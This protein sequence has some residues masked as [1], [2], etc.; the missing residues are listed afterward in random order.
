MTR[1]LRFFTI[2][3]LNCYNSHVKITAKTPRLEVAPSVPTRNEGYTRRFVDDSRLLI[4]SVCDQCG[5]RI[6][7][8]ASDR[9]AQDER[10][11]REQCPLPVRKERRQAA[12]T[13]SSESQAKQ[14]H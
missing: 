5:F 4:E 10:D 2:F 8:S 9:L 6:V 14:Q 1:F 11:H 7:G 13:S 3:S 12:A